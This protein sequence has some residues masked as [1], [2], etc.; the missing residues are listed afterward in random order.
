M[1]RFGV[2][3]RNMSQFLDVLQK[4]N[5]D[6]NLQGSANDAQTQQLIQMLR[7]LTQYD[8]TY[9]LGVYDT[10]LT[11]FANLVNNLMV[12]EIT[13]R[14]FMTSQT[15][16]NILQTLNR[17]VIP[18]EQKVF[19]RN[20]TAD[21]LFQ[22][23]ANMRDLIIRRE[24]FFFRKTDKSV[25]GEHSSLGKNIIVSTETT[26]PQGYETG[27]FSSNTPIPFMYE[28]DEVQSGNNNPT[29]RF[30][31]SLGNTSVINI[32]PI[33]KHLIFYQN[34]VPDKPLRIPSLNNQEIRLPSPFTKGFDYCK[35]AN[36]LTITQYDQM[37]QKDPP[38]LVIRSVMSRLL[39]KMLDT[40]KDRK[41]NNTSEYNAM[42][43]SV[44][45]VSR[46]PHYSFHLIRKYIHE[47]KP[48][49]SEQGCGNPGVRSFEG[50]D[51]I[52]FV[53][54]KP[55][56]ETIN[57]VYEYAER[58]TLLSDTNARPSKTLEFVNNTS[59]YLANTTGYAYM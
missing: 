13:F 45:L 31:D 40:M 1:G 38:V 34:M 57:K 53:I 11:K 52:S 8:I 28:V 44:N 35:I 7:L 9:T 30:K 58:F 39:T 59:P 32:N 50:A 54:E 47:N 48:R 16:A 4:W 2:N 18:D 41:E 5:F 14:T 10:E 55:P 26:F 49:T 22:L 25:F 33:Q 37:A 56:S 27:L 36:N 23:N 46:F 43:D 51:P 42:V 12:D 15:G 21:E 19:S 3:M 17:G 6:I 24:E 29:I 20:L